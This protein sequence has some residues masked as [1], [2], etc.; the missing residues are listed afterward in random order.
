VV[1][2]SA[3]PE[4]LWTRIHGDATTADRR[5]NLTSHGGF[6]EVAELVA[7]REPWYRETAHLIVD[8]SRSP[9]AVSDDIVM[10]LHHL[11]R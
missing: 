3:S 7:K 10:G 6:V 9:E 11:P 4:L 8:A 5:P 1:W 2:L